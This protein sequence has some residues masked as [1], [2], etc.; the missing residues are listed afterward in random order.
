MLLSSC[1]LG[2]DK[3]SGGLIDQ[4]NLNIISNINELAVD[5]FITKKSTDNDDIVSNAIDKPRFKSD[6]KE[7][8]IKNIEPYIS[9]D[10]KAKWIYDNYYNLPNIDAYLTGN[11]QDTI[12]FVYNMH[13]GNKDFPNS[14]GQSKDLGRITPFYLQWDNR[15]AYNELANRNIGIAGCGPT[16]LAMILSRIKD[17]PTITPDKIAKDAE[18]YMV[19]E[20]IGWNFFTDGSSKYGYNIKEVSN[21]EEE[22]KKALEDGP[23][24]VSINRGYFTLFGH[25]FVIDSYKD[26][27]FLINDPNSIKNSER[28]WS[29]EDISDQI[30]KIWSIN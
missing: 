16:S 7:E 1:T 17:D 27:K 12:E 3:S 21:N 18:S 8:L 30:A 9:T 6:N 29:F 25:I 10:P 13:N 22:M 23:L 4:E 26:G 11:D 20:G 5:T 2:S 14:P 24:L 19:A 28:E 15:W